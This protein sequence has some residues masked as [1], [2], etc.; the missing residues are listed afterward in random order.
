M[1]KA[2]P[3]SPEDAKAFDLAMR[4]DYGSLN[5]KTGKY[6]FPAVADW[7]GI[8][9]LSDEWMNLPGTTGN[10]R[11][12][13]AKLFDTAKFPSGPDMGS[14]RKAVT[15]PSL[16]NTNIG[17]TGE[18]IVKA[19]PEEVQMITDPN[20][21][22]HDYAGQVVGKGSSYEGKSEHIPLKE[23]WSDWYKGRPPGESEANTAFAF[24]RNSVV[25]KFTRE[26]QDK[27]MKF[28]KGGGTLGA[29]VAGGLISAEMAKEIFGHSG[30]DDDAI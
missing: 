27:L 17:D 24:G 23:F 12:K 20:L 26:M 2:K 30:E 7:P 3:L 14:V 6:D 25:Q 4:S 21:P 22:H 16:L 8:E 5:K 1:L 18:A 11:A 9:N 28:K 19:G 10:Q 13:I 15:K 29:A